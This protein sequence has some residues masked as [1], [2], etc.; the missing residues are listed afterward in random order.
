MVLFVVR[1][2][3]GGAEVWS[4]EIYSTVTTVLK[5]S[6][7]LLPYC[8]QITFCVLVE[9]QLHRLSFIVDIILSQV[10]FF[11]FGFS[12]WCLRWFYLVGKFYH[13]SSAGD[14][15]VGLI[16]SSPAMCRP[17]PEGCYPEEDP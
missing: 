4:S 2:C 13:G 17:P 5:S 10:S 12:R 14:L 9:S 7:E 3:G 1:E 15:F 6:R 16:R 8:G 11:G